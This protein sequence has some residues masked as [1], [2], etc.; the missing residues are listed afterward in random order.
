MNRLA[1]ACVSL[2]LFLAPQLGQ[3]ANASGHFFPTRPARA[4]FYRESGVLAGFGI[5]N[6]TAGVA[7]KRSDG[8]TVNFFLAFPHT[9]DGKRSTCKQV[10][11]PAVAPGFTECKEQLPSRFVVGKTHVRVTYW[12]QMYEGTRVRVTDT[13]STKP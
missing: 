6:D 4:V 5:G 1:L 2:T 9:F 10:A 7:I 12:W 11:A 3:N 13:I 8:R